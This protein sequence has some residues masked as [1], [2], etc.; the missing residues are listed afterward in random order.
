VITEGNS[1]VR[2]YRFTYNLDFHTHLNQIKEYGSDGTSFRNA[3]IFGWGETKEQ[4]TSV[5][6]VFNNG[7]KNKYYFG[8]FNGDGRTDFVTTENKASFTASDKWKFYLTSSSGTSFSFVNEG[9]LSSTFKEFAVADADGNGK[10]DI[11]WH[12][13]ETGNSEQFRY[14]YYNGSGLT[15]G[16]DE[17]DMIFTGSPTSLSLIPA[18]FDGNGIVDY[19]L[20]NSSKNFYDVRGIYVDAYPAFGTPDDVRIIDF[21]GDKKQEMLVIKGTASRIYEY[22]ITSE[23]FSQIYYATT[24]PLSTDRIYPGD[25]NGDKKTDILYWRSGSGWALKFSSGTGFVTSANPPALYNTDPGAELHS[26]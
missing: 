10:D 14:Y 15:R 4:H 11:F 3:T 16:S 6:N 9:Y 25:F 8:D 13:R 19:L 23:S 24:F 12:S 2:E 26:R 17:Y 7:I 22:D 21:N 5:D 20:L 1:L 18:D